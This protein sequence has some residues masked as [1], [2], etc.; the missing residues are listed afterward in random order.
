MKTSDG[1][2]TTALSRRYATAV[3]AFLLL[4]GLCITSA[5]AQDGRRGGERNATRRNDAG[6]GT[7]M[8]ERP[9]RNERGDRGRNDIAIDRS[10]SPHENFNSNHQQG[11]ENRSIERDRNNNNPFNR[12]RNN[13]YGNVPTPNNRERNIDRDRNSNRDIN[14]NRPVPNNNGGYNRM[15]GNYNRYQIN[16]NRPVSGSRNRP[17]YRPVYGYDRSPAYNPYNPNWR[18]GYLPRR[19]SCFYSLPSSYFNIY[20]GGMGYRYWDGIFYRP[21]NNLFTVIAP[22]IGIFINVLPIGYNR[23]YVHNYPYYYFNGT[24]YDQRGSNY[25]V[26]SPPVGSVVESLPDGYQTVVIDG[27]TYYT[28]DGAQ[29]KP[30]I[31]QDGEIHYEVIKAN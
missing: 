11:N 21:Y 18:Y 10:F 1:Y 24:Y 30:V 2:I 5:K 6:R 28:A 16:F 23:I 20:F 4:S 27:E 12:N 29:Y 7:E 19:N 25:Y 9:S 14:N 15:P 22:P 3:M 31:Q 8:R 17:G 13:N 26:V